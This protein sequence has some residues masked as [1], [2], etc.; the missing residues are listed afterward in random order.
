MNKILIKHLLLPILIVIGFGGCGYNFKKYGYSPKDLPVTLYDSLFSG[1]RYS[2]M[3]KRYGF[4]SFDYTQSDFRNLSIGLLATQSFDNR[5]RWPIKERLPDKFDPAEWLE[6]GKNPGLGVIMLHEEGVTGKG[7][8][9]AIFDKP[10]NANHDEIREK[11]TYIPVSSEY[12]NHFQHKRHHFHGINCA[13][14]L[15]GKTVGVAP[16]SKL[17]YFAVPD[18]GNNTYNYCLA[19][20]ELISLNHALSE[21][22]KIRIVSISD[23]ISKNDREVF[24]WWT[25]LAEKAKKRNIAIVYSSLLIE[26]FTWGGCPPYQ[27]K[28][29][30]Q[31]Y[32]YSSWVKNNSKR[33]FK[34]KI[35]LP[36]DYRTVADNK[37]K[38][39]YRFKPAGGFSSAIPYFVGLSALAWQVDPNLEL[40]DIYKYIDESKTIRKDSSFVINPVGFIEL[41]KTRIE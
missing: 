6:G 12:A 27:D 18:D 28:N 2:S 5:T 4:S 33:N 16:D 40:E 15:C 11:I 14:I 37:D 13:S 39:R 10:I 35:I 20:E 3:D 8:S 41:V 31:N 34:N 22:E 19:L 23:G 29:L 17:F 30:P 21:N 38:F 25:E 7:I 36:G 32:D 26:Y 9:I 1:D 24:N